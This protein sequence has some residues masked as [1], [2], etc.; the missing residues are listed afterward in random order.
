MNSNYYYFIPSACSIGTCQRYLQQSDLCNSVYESSD[1]IFTAMNQTLLSKELDGRVFPILS[2]ECGNLISKVLCHSFF[3]PCGA[4]GLLHLPLTLCPDECHYVEIAC[5]Y[6]WVVVNNMLA[7]STKLNSINC[8][9]TG[10]LLQGL[11]L[12][13]IDSGIEIKG[14][15]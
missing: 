13:C 6:Q 1:Y 14:N 11:T 3:P 2:G 5:A 4:N 7:G 12:C 9:A 8:E 15:E 10:A